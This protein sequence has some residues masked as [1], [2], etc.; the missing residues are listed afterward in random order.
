MGKRDKDEC[1]ARDESFVTSCISSRWTKSVFSDIYD[2]T[3]D[4][5][6]LLLQNSSISM[7][8][9]QFTTKRKTQ[10]RT[11]GKRSHGRMRINR[12]MRMMVTS[13]R[14]RSWKVFYDATD[15]A[16]LLLLENSFISVK[17]WNWS[18]PRG[19]LILYQ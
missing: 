5:L 11:N 9:L 4:S 7:K 14:L 15:D 16:L 12:K 2:A 17:E 19:I 6:L 3:V 10:L 13:S 8:K 1:R 18:S